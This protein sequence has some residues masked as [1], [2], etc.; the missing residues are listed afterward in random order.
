MFVHLDLKWWAHPFALSSFRLTTAEQ[1][2]AIKA[3]G[4]Q[5][6]RWSP[7]KSD[8][9]TLDAPL[10]AAEE[11]AQAPDTASETPQ[12]QQWRQR[13]EQLAQQLEAHR[14]CTR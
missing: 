9:G 1:I 5:R 10:A 7:E 4:I 8:A 12:Q 6:V 11:S 14:V 2:A 13:R 3:L